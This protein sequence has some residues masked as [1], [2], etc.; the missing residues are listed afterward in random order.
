MKSP[1]VTQQIRVRCES[2]AI[3]D[4][5]KPRQGALCSCYFP[6]YSSPPTQTVHT[7]NKH[8]LISSK[9]YL[10]CRRSTHALHTLAHLFC[11]A[12]QGVGACIIPLRR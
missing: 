9:Q 2:C 11:P 10:Q 6:D 3:A 8:V 4:G 12:A 5:L 7:I 1:K